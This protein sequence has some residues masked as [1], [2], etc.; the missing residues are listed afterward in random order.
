MPDPT[1]LFNPAREIQEARYWAD[2][3][4]HEGRNN[5]NVFSQWQYGGAQNPWCDSFVSY[6]AWIGGFRFPPYSACGDKGEFNVGT[7]HQHA[8]REGIWR[9]PSTVARPGWLV[10]FSFTIPDEHI[11][12]VLS[13]DGGRELET[14]GG[15]TGNEVAYRTRQRTNVVG[16]I[17]L[18]EAG[19]N[20]P[21][22]AQ[23]DLSVNST[24]S[25]DAVR[26][27]AGGVYVLKADGGVFAYGG[28]PFYGSA[29][30][31]GVHWDM[32]AA[33]ATSIMLTPS[34]Q[35]YWI[36]GANG[37]VVTCGDA[38]FHGTFHGQLPLATA[39]QLVA[40]GDSYRA[41]RDS[42]GAVLSPVAGK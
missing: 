26:T 12:M 27:H 8:I 39:V 21:G 3:G 18:D 34:Q 11:E 32:K 30:G 23:G 19:Q 37:D 33:W 14:I 31:K 7:S 41:I 25:M 28:A 20:A 10:V 38:E 15:N 9:E 4:Y 16:F 6:C 2:I 40:D 29:P 42:D 1:G 17:A 13:D 24:D 22:R 36:L 35:G 5:A